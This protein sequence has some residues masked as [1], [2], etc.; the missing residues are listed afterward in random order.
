MGA[1]RN[2]ESHH[3][4]QARP[5][6]QNIRPSIC[7]NRSNTEMFQPVIGQLASVK[8]NLQVI[9]KTAKF[10]VRSVILPISASTTE[11]FFDLSTPSDRFALRE[12]SLRHPKTKHYS[13][14]FA[15]RAH[16][17]QEML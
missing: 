6:H 14:W 1:L 5:E 3:A 17:Y 9:E 10:W 13:A 11:H 8:A 15:R 2:R 7:F 4:P 16:H 12:I